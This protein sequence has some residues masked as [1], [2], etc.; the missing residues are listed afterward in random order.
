MSTPPPRRE[1]LSVLCLGVGKGATHFKSGEPSSAYAICR[2]DE[3]VLVLD[4]GPGTG[5]SY[6]R[7]IGDTWPKHLYVSHNHADHAAELPM[8]VTSQTMHDEQL[9][10]YAHPDV[11]GILRERRLHECPYVADGVVW[12]EADADNRLQLPDF[13]LRLVRSAHSYLTYGFVLEIDGQ[14]R[15]GWSSDCSY[16]ESVYATLFAAPIVVLH[17][18]DGGNHDH[19]DFRA[20]ETFAA[21]YETEVRLSHYEQSAFAFSAPNVALLGVGERL[22][23]AD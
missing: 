2:G 12:H 11:A 19:A 3:A 13:S 1:P 10:I 20:V 9:H 6:R 5:L 8:F 22:L 7:H 16:D 15:F 23:I 21:A 18:R 14:P 17:A 4:C